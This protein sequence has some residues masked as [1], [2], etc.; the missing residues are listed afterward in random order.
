MAYL[1]QL[2]QKEVYT[3]F[4]NP[5]DWR[6]TDLTM[7]CANTAA[8]SKTFV[9]NPKPLSEY[10]IGSAD[11]RMTGTHPGQLESVMHFHG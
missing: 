5:K 7:G 11:S 8:W 2:L 3:A 6:Y 4:A 1:L 9:Q 10:G